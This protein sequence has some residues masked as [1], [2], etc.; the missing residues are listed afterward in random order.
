MTGIVQITPFI[1]TRDIDASCAVF[2]SIAFTPTHTGDSPGNAYCQ[3]HGRA[4][5]VLEISPEAELGEQM[6]YL[7]LGKVDPFYKSLRPALDVL[8]KGRVRAPFNQPYAKREFHAKD[9]ENCLMLFGSRIMR[10]ADNP[11]RH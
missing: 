11:G 7:D 10:V 1:S 3:G 4:L 8:P 6:I 5:H 9:P 2:E